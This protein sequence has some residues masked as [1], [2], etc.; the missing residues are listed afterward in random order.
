[1]KIIPGVELF[2][3]DANFILFKI[4]NADRI[5]RE[6]IERDI[7]IRNFNSPGRLENCLRV[8]I[9]TKEENEAFLKALTGILS[10]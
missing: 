8:T 9:G 5:Y 2:S 10:S 1:M 7:L 3:T 6:L 4:N